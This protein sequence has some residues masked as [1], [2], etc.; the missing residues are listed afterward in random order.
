MDFK[1]FEYNPKLV[2]VGASETIVNYDTT[3]RENLGAQ[4]EGDVRP[5]Y[6][7]T[8]I[9]VGPSVVHRSWCGYW[10]DVVRHFL[11]PRQLRLVGI[12]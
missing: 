8:F 11:A 2:G 4:Y 6:P 3:N 7:L 10:E 12:A 9:D 1:H 5:G